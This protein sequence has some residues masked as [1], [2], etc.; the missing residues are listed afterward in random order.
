M[1]LVTFC[2]DLIWSP[3]LKNATEGSIKITFHFIAKELP[4]TLFHLFWPPVSGT[5]L[6]LCTDGGAKGNKGLHGWV[7]GTKKK[8]LWECSGPAPGWFTNSFRSKEVGQLAILVFIKVNLDYDQL[9]D[10]QLPQFHAAADPW[11]RIA[12]DNQGLIA[13]VRMGVATKTVFAGAA[14]SPK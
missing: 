2:L 6:L 10:V 11:L 14:L 13:H 8:L 7:I 4:Q 9:H 3:S 5:R 12:T 1:P